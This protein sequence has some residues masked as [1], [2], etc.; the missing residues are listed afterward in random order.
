MRI[1]NWGNYPF[2][3]AD[4][5]ELDRIKHFQRALESSTPLIARGLGRCYGDSALSDTILSTRTFNR[6]ISFDDHT[7]TLTCES[8]VSFAD[9]L[10]TF[11]PRGWFPPVT[12]G[13]KFV[14][15]GGAIASDVHGKNHHVAGAISNHILSL[16]I[17]LSSGQIVSCSPTEN[18]QLFWSTCG[19][20]GM[21]GIILQ[22]TLKLIPIKSAYIKQETIA[23]KNLDQIMDIF[24]HS[25]SWTYT[26]AWL[27]CLA[28]GLNQ[29]RS[30]MMRG[31]HADPQDLI[32]SEQT[33]TP[34]Q[35]PAKKHFNIPVN[36]PNLALNQFTVRAFNFLYYNKAP[37]ECR[38]AIIDY[39]QFFYPLDSILNWNRIYGKR[40]FT[41]Y[42][43]VLPKQNSRSG[44]Q[45]ILSA[46]SKAGLGSFLVVLKLF[47]KQNSL[48]S[49]PT[50]GYT[51]ALDFPI[52]P[53]LF[54]FLTSL[55]AIVLDNGGRLY[56]TKDV[57]MN[58][59]MFKGSYSNSAEFIR[60]KH[61][62]D[63]DNRFQSLQS[64]RLG[65]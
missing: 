21:T 13:T 11:V 62:F 24:E 44:L 43:F 14:T 59:Q 16:D 65:I 41:Q 18:D 42:Q 58:E 20:M 60:L 31:E 54:P 53:G 57:R 2:I 55:D 48:I 46:I 4:V 10:E 61:Q 45:K 56:L 8:G 25:E 26:V 27:D 36:F 23:A 3:N 32:T 64:R 37:N 9:I 63:P 40:G 19:G 28:S 47:G 38:Q 22:A 35:L 52:T 51:L 33:S 17:L 15:I 30:V 5:Q 50:E 49:F 6:F 1:S 39:D 29:G 34:L 12:P 7:G